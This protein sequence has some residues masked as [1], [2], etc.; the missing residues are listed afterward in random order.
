M[1][2]AAQLTSTQARPQSIENLQSILDAKVDKSNETKILICSQKDMGGNQS[3]V[4]YKL[5]REYAKTDL[6]G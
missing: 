3:S 6:K 5:G 1:H 2:Q 4:F